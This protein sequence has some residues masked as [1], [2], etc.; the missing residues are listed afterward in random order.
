MVLHARNRLGNLEQPVHGAADDLEAVAVGQARIGEQF[1]AFAQGNVCHVV[2]T[3]VEPRQVAVFQVGKR[4]QQGLGRGGGRIIAAVI[5]GQCYRHG[6]VG[7]GR[8][9]AAEHAGKG[10]FDFADQAVSFLLRGG[11]GRCVVFGFGADA[12]YGRGFGRRVVGLA[13][14]RHFAG[15]RFVVE[16]DAVIVFVCKARN[17]VGDLSGG[18]V[19]RL[20]HRCCCGCGFD[21][22][23]VVGVVVGGRRRG[24][25]H[26]GGLQAL[27]FAFD[28]VLGIARQG[29]G[30]DVVFVNGIVSVPHGLQLY[31]HQCVAVGMTEL[32][33]DFVAVAFFLKHVVPQH[34]PQYDTQCN[35]D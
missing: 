4:Y 32:A 9:A 23:A 25:A 27:A 2:G 35:N 22:H 12:R 1:R 16:T 10:G 18:V 7:G 6:F 34:A 17:V 29:G 19:L 5:G 33:A 24:F 13:G 21:E 14:K 31:A 26:D 20:P 15:R 3:G 8:V 11:G 28:I 30:R